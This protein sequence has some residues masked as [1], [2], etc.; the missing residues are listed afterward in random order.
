MTVSRHVLLFTIFAHIEHISSFVESLMLT[1]KAC[2]K[3][4]G[5]G[6]MLVCAGKWR[7]SR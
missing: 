4:L 7:S 2:Q 1:V 5:S 3:V 6:C